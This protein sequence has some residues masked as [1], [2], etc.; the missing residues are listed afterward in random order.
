MIATIGYVA[1]HAGD[2]LAAIHFDRRDPGPKDVLLQVLW[3]GVCHSDVSMVDNDWGFSLFPMV[4][5]HEIVGLVTKVGVEVKKLR[6][7][8]IAEAQGDTEL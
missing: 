2:E 6:V 8:D 3:C 5:G 7:G 4:P 1:Q